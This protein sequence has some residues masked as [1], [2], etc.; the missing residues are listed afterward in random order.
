MNG[1]YVLTLWSGDDKPV[2][3]QFVR[4][5]AGKNVEEVRFSALDHPHVVTTGTLHRPGEVY[6]FS[7]DRVIAKGDIITFGKGSIALNIESDPPAKK[8][9][10]PVVPTAWERIQ[11]EES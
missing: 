7:I 4:L 6:H 10:I 9:E 3:V 11:K 1:I 2:G 5:V 8:T